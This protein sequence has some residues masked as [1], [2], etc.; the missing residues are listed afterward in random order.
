[1]NNK[2]KNYIYLNIVF[3]ILSIYVIL[4]P[5][6][7]IPLK[8]IVPSFG[9]CPYFRITGNYCPLCGGTRYLSNIYRAFKNPFYLI[10]PFGIIIM[11]VLFE[12][13]F[14]VFILTKKLYNKKIVIFDIIYHLTLFIIFIAYEFFFFMLK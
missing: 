3:L 13:I 1:M 2:Q 10:H 9:V 7:I 14:R 12:I 11:C 6:I 4:F 5:I 8:A